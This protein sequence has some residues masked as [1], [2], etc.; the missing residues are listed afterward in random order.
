MT[1][2]WT[3][4][5]G[6]DW[7]YDNIELADSNSNKYRWSFGA[8]PWN[9]SIIATK[10]NGDVVQL[11]EPMK[12]VYSYDK[13][14]DR[15]KDLTSYSFLVNVDE[16]NPVRKYSNVCTTS[17]VG[18]GFEKCTLTPDSFVGKKFSLEY[19]PRIPIDTTFRLG[20]VI[21]S[22]EILGCKFFAASFLPTKNLIFP[23]FIS[24]STGVV[25]DTSL[26][27]MYRN[28]FLKSPLSESK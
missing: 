9:Q 5:G 6:N 1:D 12:F 13:N 10:A 14:A 21:T 15:N 26:L 3:S 2:G 23:G 17:G 20:S 27:E 4:D 7:P 16:H 18:S 24:A 25:I 28:N 22:T 8:H 19:P 11:D